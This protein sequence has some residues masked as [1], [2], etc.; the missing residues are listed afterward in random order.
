M[1]PFPY[2]LIVF[3]TI[4]ALTKLCNLNIQQYNEHFHS[5]IYILTPFVER[6]TKTSRSIPFL[7]TST[8]QSLVLEVKVSLRH[9][10][11]TYILQKKSLENKI[12][13]CTFTTNTQLK[14]AVEKL[15]LLCA[16]LHSAFLVVLIQ[17]SVEKCCNAPIWLQSGQW[18]RGRALWLAGSSLPN[19]NN[20]SYNKIKT[21][22]KCH[23]CTNHD[24]LFVQ[25]KATQIMCQLWDWF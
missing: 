21:V 18:N 15:L 1:C 20:T 11:T 19:T 6:T 17:N 24:R 22:T 10:N 13:I 5:Q 16:V 25:Q 8:R 12:E 4:C 7:L 3:F 9:T 2:I 14:G 23:L